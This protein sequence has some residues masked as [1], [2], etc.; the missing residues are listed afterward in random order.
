MKI[1][2]VGSG[3]GGLSAA[4]LLS[5]RHEVTLFEQS[6]ALGMDAHSIDIETADGMARVDV[7][8][9]VFFDGYYPN[10]A[11]LYREL[12]IDFEPINYAAS[13]GLLDQKTH[14]RFDNY[15]LGRLAVPF[16][17]GR[18]SFRRTA[19]RIGL[20]NLRFF[21]ELSVSVASGRIAQDTSLSDYVAANNY[22]RDFAEGFLYPAFAGICTCCL[23]SVK[24]YPAQ[25]IL[26]Y[27]NSDLLLRSVQRVTMGTRQVVGRLAKNVHS[28]RLNTT[29]T[30]V[31][32]STNG[33]TIRSDQGVSEYDHAVIAVQA[34]QANDLLQGSASDDRRVLGQFNYEPSQVVVHTDE[35]LAPRGGPSQWAPVNFIA[36]DYGSTPMA[37]IWLNSIQDLPGQQA[38]FQTWNP[39]RAPEPNKILSQAAFERPVVT[40]QSMAALSDLTAL[41]SEPNRRVWYCGSYASRGIPLLESAADSAFEVAEK[42]GCQR[43]R[44]RNSSSSSM[45]DLIVDPTTP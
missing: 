25:V 2:V 11:A 14:F 8:L 44:G 7:P 42:L 27:L 21:R 16:L 34:N 23:E 26:E 38:V 32:P 31:D 1:A 36:N 40:A 4:W 17:K 20:D 43:P 5:A 19:L 45:P 41:H 28:V 13:F 18:L 37:T 29:V 22:S 39:I 15:K 9:R 6:A 33:V 30:A 35:R 10:I 12:Q 24:A 3:I